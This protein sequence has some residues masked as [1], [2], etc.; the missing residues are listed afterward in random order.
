MKT[1]NV[2]AS[3]FPVVATT[4]L[5]LAQA[6]TLSA[7]TSPLGDLLPGP[8]P[9]VQTTPRVAAGGGGYLVVWT[10][11]RSHVGGTQSDLD[12]FALR[13]DDLGA[14]LDPA[15]IPV[16]V[17][18]GWQRNPRVAWNGADWLVVFEDQL[19][20]GSYYSTA[21]SAA[22]VSSAGV[23]LDPAG[24]RVRPAQWSD[25]VLWDLCANG[26]EWVVA[27]SGTSGGEAALTG[28]RIGA[29]GAVV[30]PAGTVLVPETYFL[31]F[32]VNLASSQGEVL[33][34]YT[35]ASTPVARRY[36]PTLAAIGAA[37][38][39]PGTNVGGGTLG[40]YVTWNGTT[41]LLGSPMTLDGT[42][43]F[44]AGLAIESTFGITQVAKPAW[45]GSQWWIGWSNIVD[46]IVAARV[47]TSGTLIDAGGVQVAAVGGS[48][49]TGLSIAG[50]AAAGAQ[51]AWTGQGQ[52]YEVFGANATPAFVVGPVAALSTSAPSQ[53]RP[54]LCAGPD[55]WALAYESQNGETRRVLF[56]LLDPEGGGRTAEPIE[57]GS[58]PGRGGA[59]VAW[60]GAVYAVAWNDGLRIVVQRFALDGTPVD[61]APLLVMA[62]DSGAAIA[63]VGRAFLIGT[64]VAETYPQFRDAVVRRF[65]GD[66]GAFL[67]P[68]PVVLGAGYAQ[69]LRA[70]SMVDRWL[71]VWQSNWSHNDPQATN[72]AAI[73]LPDGTVSTNTGVD[74]G[75]SPDAA[76]GNGSAL[77]VWRLNSLANANNDVACCTIQ[78]N[79]ALGPKV[80]VSTAV[81]RQLSPRVAWDGTQWLLAWED[82]RHQTS[83]F[84]AETDV[85]GARVSAAARCSTPR[86]SRGASPRCR[87]RSRCSPRAARA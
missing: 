82:Q 27:S 42:L 75:G 69:Q 74:F 80:V 68:A 58:G 56:R 70:T 33:L 55:G 51:F 81:G 28:H 87:S 25:S 63:A 4:A 64:T 34:T 79:G 66:S 41:D 83:F 8:A 3:L 19:F 46:G 18:P 61:A 49:P 15:P 22:R 67:D 44:P 76:G 73:V 71:V 14:P 9:D 85:Y 11:A 59:A 2:I 65:D 29:N 52:Q 78:P 20:N 53:L 43:A 38:T 7:P 48:N 5:A 45:D 32:G 24:F 10:D 57:L 77:I 50:G 54:A 16:A 62:S 30:N 84:D 23:V 21:L 12:V 1:P 86:A 26:S 31:Y 13:L 47:A 36:G 6:P 60:N 40:Y 72:I 17:R 35:G 39:P 37:F